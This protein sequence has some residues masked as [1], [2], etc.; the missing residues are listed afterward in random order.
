[1]SL[2]RGQKLGQWH[3][4]KTR[5]S[6]VTGYFELRAERRKGGWIAYVDV[7][8]PQGDGYGDLPLTTPE[9]DEGATREDAERVACETARDLADELIEAARMA[10]ERKPKSSA[11]FVPPEPRAVLTIAAVL[12]A[13]RTLSANNVSPPYELRTMR[14][15]IEGMFAQ[16]GE[17]R[18]AGP[19][20]V[21]PDLILEPGE[22]FMGSVAHTRLIAVDNPTTSGFVCGKRDLPAF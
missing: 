4:T 19:A 18:E 1:M 14:S 11:P 9:T 5:S 21:P 7:A 16:F 6:L 2:V 3:R 17:M 8:E 15:A 20:V 13:E 12:D 22:T 10:P